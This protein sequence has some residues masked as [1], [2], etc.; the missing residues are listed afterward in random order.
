MIKEAPQKKSAPLYRR[1]A[2]L[3]SPRQQGMPSILNTSTQPMDRL[4]HLK[5]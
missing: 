4:E 5:A 1:F 3:I 2:Q